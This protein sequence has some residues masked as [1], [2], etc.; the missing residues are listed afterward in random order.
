MCSGV[1]TPLQGHCST[2]LLRCCLCFV[3]PDMGVYNAC[4]ERHGKKGL[5]MDTLEVTVRGRA[6]A[7][8]VFAEW[9]RMQ[10]TPLRKGLPAVEIG[11]SGI[12]IYYETA[13]LEITLPCEV[14]YAL[15]HEPPP[16]SATVRR[17]GPEEP[18]G[19]N[20]HVATYLLRLELGGG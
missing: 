19:G 12:D 8:L 7:A 4:S 9:L 6:L 17:V 2:P 5:T 14:V 3:V 11:E 20:A 16:T 18:L 1:Y 15:A 13:Q 10:G